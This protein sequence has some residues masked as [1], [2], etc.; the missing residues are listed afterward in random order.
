[1]NAGFLM[2]ISG[3]SLGGCFVVSAAVVHM[4]AHLRSRVHVCVHFHVAIMIMGG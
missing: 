2:F 1:M 4:V 3:F